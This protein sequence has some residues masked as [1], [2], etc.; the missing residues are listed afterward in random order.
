M[1]RYI[2]ILIAAFFLL[3]VGSG[4]VI[5]PFYGDINVIDEGQFGGWITHM[6]HGQKLYVDTYA[7]YGPLYIYPLYFASKLFGPSVF[8]IR[9]IYLVIGTLGALIIAKWAMQRLKIKEYIQYMVLSLLIIIPGFGMRQGMGLIALLALDKGIA[10]NNPKWWMITGA[11]VCITFLVSSDMGI[12]VGIISALSVFIASIHAEKLKSVLINTAGYLVGI[13]VPFLIFSILAYQDGWLTAYIQTVVDDYIS[14]SGMGLPNG[15]A[16]PNLLTLFF[17]A[18]S[19]WAMVKVILSREAILYWN[20]LLYFCLVAFIVIKF[21]LKGRL[22]DTYLSFITI[23]GFMLSMIL[24]GR[25]GHIPFVIP[26]S[27]ILMGYLC[28]RV[29][30]LPKGKLKIVIIVAMVIFSLRFVSLYRPHF[31]RILEIPSNFFQNTASASYIGPISISREQDEQFLFVQKFVHEN[32]EKNES[33]F[34]LGNEP[35]MY[36]VA[37]RTNPSRFDLPEVINSK[38]KR[39]ELIES[40]EKK[41]TKYILYNKSSWD[42]DGVSNAQRLPE[43]MEY[44]GQKYTSSEQ[45]GFVIYK[46]R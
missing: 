3:L 29:L 40:L 23:F 21:L 32:V 10:K 25:F 22:V 44:I 20:Y 7:A 4:L 28:S 1:K 12:F 31:G 33:I 24:L 38:A 35:V 16:F 36:L 37:N 43:L 13:V 45:Q 19:P 9:I 46:R 8:L 11:T 26:I 41:E 27:F 14:Y 30:L 17:E 6:L 18:N 2:W 5:S 15:Q 42:V 39:Y 34:F